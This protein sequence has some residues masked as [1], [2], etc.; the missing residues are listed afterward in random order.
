MHVSDFSEKTFPLEAFC[1]GSKDL[2]IFET[3]NVVIK[4]KIFV[5]IVVLCT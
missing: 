2:I 3:F 4:A 5:K 1:L